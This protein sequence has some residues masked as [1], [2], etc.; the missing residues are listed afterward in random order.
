MPTPVNRF[1]S[2]VRQIVE[3]LKAAFPALG[4]LRI[5]NMLARAGLHVARS[6]VRRFLE[7]HA[8]PP[9]PAAPHPANAAHGLLPAPAAVG[10]GSSRS[11]RIISRGPN[12]TWLVDLTIVPTAAGFWVPWLP[13]A[14]LQR[15][16]FCW[17]VAVVIDHFSRKAVGHA[18]FKKQPTGKELCA[19]LGRVVRNVGRPP[20]YIITDQGAQFAT[21]YRAWCA[22]RGIRPRFGALGRHGSIALVERFIR[23]LKDE[24]LRRVLV[25]FR[26]SMMQVEVASFVD[27]YNTSR[28]H[29]ALGGAT[30]TEVYRGRRP[31]NTGPR[32]ETRA[33]Y[34]ARGRG[35]L[36]APQGTPLRLCI[37]YHEGR[38]HLPVVRLRKAA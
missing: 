34:P 25:P 30:P 33:R 16:P 27:W 17:W 21:A 7:A 8:H 12:H 35:K 13:N 1:P 26:L 14:L 10:S 15:W 19:F 31:A 18:T 9:S 23:S 28:P 32:F 5:A 4:T 11:P 2:F 38:R 29:M 24:G 3:R 37:G 36:R 6:T 20:K 22:S